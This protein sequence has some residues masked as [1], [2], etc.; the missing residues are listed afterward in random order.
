MRISNIQYDTL[1]Y[2]ELDHYLYQMNYSSLEEL[3]ESMVK[4]YIK[5]YILFIIV[6][7]SI[8]Y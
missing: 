2:I 4:F 1:N 7:I 5:S 8:I 6:I 3:S